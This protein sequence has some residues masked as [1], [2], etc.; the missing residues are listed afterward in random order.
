MVLD[1]QTL[2][3]VAAGLAASVAGVFALAW[4]Q[5]P[6][7]PALRYWSWTYLLNA[8]GLLLI[9]ARN[10]VPVKP[11]LIASN[12]SVG[13]AAIALLA[14]SRSFL[15][16]G[17]LHRLVWLPFILAMSGI[18]YFTYIDVNFVARVTIA[19]TYLGSMAL[20]VA[21]EHLRQ[22]AAEQTAPMRAMIALMLLHVAVHGGRVVSFAT[23]W[24]TSA[25]LLDPTL[26]QTIVFYEACLFVV[27]VPI[28]CL[29]MTAERLQTHLRHTASTDSL[30]GL[31]N[32]RAFLEESDR[33]FRQARRSQGTIT[34]MLIDI[35]HFKA[36]NDRHGHGA[37]DAVLIG[38]ARLLDV[39]LRRSD[40]AC[41]Y[42][43][44]EFC[45]LLPDTGAA[46]ALRVAETLRA[47]FSGAGFQ[48][49]GETVGTTLSIGIAENGPSVD[50]LEGLISRADAA[51]YRMKRA[52][53][54]R[55]AISEEVPIPANLA[56]PQSAC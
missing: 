50:T 7:I 17:P 34:L 2:I 21:V 56:I 47:R 38:L 29:V 39:S 15:G 1:T 19:S 33:R 40:L 13:L 41:R 51:L 35:D 54:N 6:G 9:L 44:D 4:R 16:R 42:G 43:G 53:R 36:V 8:L 5:H 27:L 10:T 28:V 32:R 52:G 18:F 12:V 26:I 30:T 25:D 11:L 37:G 3:L 55:A 31:M 46:A 48:S 45:V 14:A 24:T 49:A 23:G 20:W 22:P